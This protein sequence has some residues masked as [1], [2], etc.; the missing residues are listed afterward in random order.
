M[1]KRPIINKHPPKAQK[2]QTRHQFAYFLAGLIDGDGSIDKKGNIIIC[3][4][5]RDL[6][7]AYYVKKIIGHGH[8]RKVKNKI[9]WVY[10]CTNAAGNTMIANLIWDKIRHPSRILQLNPHML[11]T[12]T[13]GSQ[14]KCGDTKPFDLNNHWLAGFLQADGCFQIKILENRVKTTSSTYRTETRVVIQVDQKESFLLHMMKDH[15]GGYIGYIPK[16]ARYYYSSVS[17]HNCVLWIRYLDK[18]QVM[19]SSLTLYWMW[20]KCYLLVQEK[21][22]LNSDGVEKIKMLKRKMTMLRNPKFDSIS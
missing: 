17:F 6:S 4:H 5:S 9:T 18:F 11:S 2:P 16:Q 1:L 19:G 15:L 10:N 8:V 21:M 13:C 22:H 3:F 7:V 12:M 14:I 20:R